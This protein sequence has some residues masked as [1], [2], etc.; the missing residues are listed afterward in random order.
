LSPRKCCGARGEV[1]VGEVAAAAARDA[2]LLGDFSRVVHQQH[3]EA[4]LAG[5]RG[6]EQAGGAGADHDDV[7]WMCQ[8][9]PCPMAPVQ[10]FQVNGNLSCFKKPFGT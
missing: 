10:P 8:I 6:A 4:A 1:A 2:D 9:S 7:K 5:L 3:L